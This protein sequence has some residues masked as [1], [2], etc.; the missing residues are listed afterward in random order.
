MF[1]IA[2]P[3]NANPA[4]QTWA[5][6]SL[7]SLTRFWDENRSPEFSDD[8]KEHLKALAQ[9]TEAEATQFASE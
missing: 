6:L 9:V 2:Y 4:T 3:H 1:L 8:V 5:L 7:M